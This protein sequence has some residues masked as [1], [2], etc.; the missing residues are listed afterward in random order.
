MAV[1]LPVEDSETDTLDDTVD[2]AL[3]DSVVEAVLDTELV[4]PVEAV[5]VPVA[6]TVVRQLSSQA[7]AMASVTT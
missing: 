6:G 3:T 7:G 1:V 2:V 5:E 4:I